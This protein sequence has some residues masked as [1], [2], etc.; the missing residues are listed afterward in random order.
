[1]DKDPVCGMAV[2]RADVGGS[3]EYQG[4]TFY[5]CSP[6]CKRAFDADPK[7]YAIFAAPAT[8]RDGR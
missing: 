3:S 6:L 2:T 1:M 7:R 4:K 5:F 8:F